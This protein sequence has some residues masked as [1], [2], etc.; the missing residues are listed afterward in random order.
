MDA[1][2]ARLRGSP[3]LGNETLEFRVTPWDSMQHFWN[4]MGMVHGI[5]GETMQKPP[6]GMGIGECA[7]CI[8]EKRYASALWPN[9]KNEVQVPSKPC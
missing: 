2:P 7:G 8:L 9:S 1:L 5:Y 3:L 6:I 4:T